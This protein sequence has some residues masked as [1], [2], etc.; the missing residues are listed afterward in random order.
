MSASNKSSRVLAAMQEFS[1]GISRFEVELRAPG[2]EER[3]IPANTI[4][5]ILYKLE[6]LRCI[7]RAKKKTILEWAQT[8][9]LD[10]V[11]HGRYVTIRKVD[12]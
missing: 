6:D 7:S 8:A 9:E 11:V 1:I 12:Y 2:S 5:Y 4:D 3:L 10:D